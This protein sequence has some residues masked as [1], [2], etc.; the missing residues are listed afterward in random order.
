MVCFGAMGRAAARSGEVASTNVA[1]DS[2]PVA[3]SSPPPKSRA[4]RFATASS[5]DLFAEASVRRCDVCSKP[6]H[7]A[8]EEHGTGVYIWARAGEVRR[9]EAPLCAACGGT[10][11]ASALG[12]IDWGDEE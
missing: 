3:K 4:A 5:A 10:I 9:E 6:L 1:H 2:T 7:G 11:I 12:M 8:E